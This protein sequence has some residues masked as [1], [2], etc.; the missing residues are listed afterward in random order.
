MSQNCFSAMI[1]LNKK[2]EPALVSVEVNI[3]WDRPLQGFF[4]T[5]YRTHT[6]HLVY[7]NLDDKAL[8]KQMGFSSTVEHFEEVLKSYGITL[9]D[10]IKAQLYK[11]KNE[12]TGNATRYW[13]NESPASIV[14]E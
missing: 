12:N 3:G 10:V 9:D 1:A 11:D 14:R 6:D 7:S 4:M 8:K 5:I 2:N 13:R